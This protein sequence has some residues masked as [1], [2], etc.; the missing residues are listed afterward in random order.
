MLIDTYELEKKVNT[1]LRQEL[2]ARELKKEYASLADE[3]FTDNIFFQAFQEAVENNIPKTVV[4][5]ILEDTNKL[6]AEYSNR[7]MTEDIIKAL[8]EYGY[9]KPVVPRTE[10][11]ALEDLSEGYTILLLNRDGTENFATS[12]FDIK[13][14]IANGG[15]VAT[16]SFTIDDIAEKMY[17]VL[18]E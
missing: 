10:E 1:V 17:E 13:N 9:S 7:Y 6:V 12:P 14:H 4:E 11:Q 16:P 3:Y 5:K 18:E 15:M 2:S 8:T